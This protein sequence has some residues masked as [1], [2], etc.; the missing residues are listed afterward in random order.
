M[1]RRVAMG[2]IPFFLAVSLDI[3]IMEA[4]AAFKGEE[5]PNDHWEMIIAK[6]A[7]EN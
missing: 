6:V 2:W 5:F 4:A 1:E 3:R 7:M